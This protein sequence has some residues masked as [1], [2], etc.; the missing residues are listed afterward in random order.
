MRFRRT[1]HH[2]SGKINVTPLI[3]VV[4]CL[5]VFYLIVGRLASSRITKLDL[6]VTSTAQEVQAASAGSN[7]I[8]TVTP[9]DAPAAP[10]RVF[11]DGVSLSIDELGGAMRRLAANPRPPTVELR[12]DRRLSYGQLAPV[13]EACRAA[14]LTSLRLKTQQSAGRDFQ[15]NP[16][17]NSKPNPKPDP[18]SD[19]SQAAPGGGR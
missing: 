7:P 10:A 6:P 8:I 17:P 3:D 1:Q 9:P 13:I 4:M 15:P 11:L 14:G 2:D 19:P 5:I 12:A 18:R 16:T